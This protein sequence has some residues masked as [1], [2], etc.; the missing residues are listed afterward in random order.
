MQRLVTGILAAMIAGTI[1]AQA[2]S[3]VVNETIAIVDPTTP[4]LQAAVT[5]AGALKVD[6][7]AATGG[8]VQ[9]VPGAANG[10]STY[11]VQPGASDNHAVIKAGA[12]TVYGIAVFNNSATINY[13]RLYDATTGF[14]GCNAATNLVTQIQIPAST[15]V[16]GA[17]IPFP[18]GVAFSTGISICVSSC[19]ATTD[20]TAATAS[21]MSVTVSYK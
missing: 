9:P 11:F 17:V 4:S 14:N 3:P 21:A 10:T 1:A 16:A 5:S 13:L 18:L 2:A 8:T 20:T 12:G 7:S 19:Y 15:S 6:A